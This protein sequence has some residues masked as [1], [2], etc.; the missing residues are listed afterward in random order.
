VALA[1]NAQA[2]LPGVRLVPFVEDFHNYVE[3]Q[4]PQQVAIVTVDSRRARRSIQSEVP[5]HVIDASTTDI[6]AVVV[7]SHKQPTS[8]ACL[9]CIYR[10]VPDENTREQAIAEG[11]GIDVSTVKESLISAAAAA[12]I[13]RLNPEVVASAI[14][15]TAYDS[16]FKALCAEQ[17]L[18]AR[19][20]WSR[21]SASRLA[22]R[23]PTTGRS[24]LGAGRSAASG[25][26]ARACQVASS[27]P[28]RTLSQSSTA[29][30]APV[31]LDRFFTVSSNT[32]AS[33]GDLVTRLGDRSSANRRA[34]AQV[35]EQ[36]IAVSVIHEGKVLRVYRA[37]KFPRSSLDAGAA[38][39]RGLCTATRA[40]PPLRRFRRSSKYMPAGGFRWLESD[41]GK[42][43]LALY[44]QVLHQHLS[45][46][47]ILLRP[48]FPDEDEG[49]IRTRTGPRR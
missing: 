40:P 24:I 15:G 45:Y 8:H 3:R 16:L 43:L 37:P 14:E 12:K 41:W 26:F 13:A 25:V 38:V 10:H 33:R 47:H 30:G 48:E 5:G 36:P 23:P 17:A 7:H 20:S 35:H 19:C 22:W 27:A 4:G 44:K 34:Y 46:G 39:P 42:P 2:E 28:S 1:R 31:L 18:L 9:S 6:R 49:S 21:C 32:N 11:L 29:C